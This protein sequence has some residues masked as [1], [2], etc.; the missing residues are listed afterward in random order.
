M[1]SP[2]LVEA[3][4]LQAIVLVLRSC[5]ETS[6]RF[7]HRLAIKNTFDVTRENKVAFFKRT[8]MRSD[9]HARLI[10][11]ECH[12]MMACSE[13]AIDRP[14]QKYAFKPLHYIPPLRHRGN[15]AHFE[16]S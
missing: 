2:Q 16:V 1:H 3:G 9:T 6:A 12:P 11:N 4:T 15:P 10:F 13:F 8:V 5:F 7:R 14:V